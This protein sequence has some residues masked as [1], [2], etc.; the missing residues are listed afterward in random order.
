M[1]SSC[2]LHVIVNRTNEMAPVHCKLLAAKADGGKE[3][4]QRFWIHEILKKRAQ[5][6]AYANL[7]RQ[8]HDD[9][10]KSRS[11]EYLRLTKMIIF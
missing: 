10:E 1:T 11:K 9:G 6:G 2:L 7:V 4:K 5:Q 3:T 8:L